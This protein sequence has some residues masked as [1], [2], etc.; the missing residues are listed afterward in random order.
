MQPF[1][2]AYLASAAT[3]LV[4]DIVWL[5]LAVPRLYRPQMGSLL[6]DQPNLAV[7][8]IFYLLYVVGIVAFVV[9]P[10]VGSGSWLSALG[11]GALLG[12]VAYGTYDFTNLATLRGWPV[13]LSFIDLT[14]G[15]FLTATSALAGY[16]ATTALSL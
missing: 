9:L 3:L 16:W 7:A 12:L 2:I 4:L 8:A 6:A 5:T 15:I 10:A 13:A 1:A 14:W 11:L